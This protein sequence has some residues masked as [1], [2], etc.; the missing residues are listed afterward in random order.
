MLDL[1][2]IESVLACMSVCVRA[3]GPP[4]RIGFTN[5]VERPTPS[6]AD[7]STAELKS[8]GTNDTMERSSHC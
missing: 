6:S 7:L 8:G 2:V 5:L 3:S 1:L 4:Y